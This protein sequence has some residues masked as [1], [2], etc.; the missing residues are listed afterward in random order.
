M[1]AAAKA[2]IGVNQDIL[3][4]REGA[5]TFVKE[6]GATA[7]EVVKRRSSVDHVAWEHFLVY[8]YPESVWVA[9]PPSATQ[10]PSA[11][12]TPTLPPPLQPLFMTKGFTE[13]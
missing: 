9:T 7:A 12:R 2:S 3:Q 4:D 5:K 13:A 11:N 8:L 6:C 10:P 1:I